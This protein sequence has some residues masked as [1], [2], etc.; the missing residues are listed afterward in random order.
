MRGIPEILEHSRTIDGGPVHRHQRAQ[1]KG[2]KL[3]KV[4]LQW[5]T[6]QEHRYNVLVRLDRQLPFFLDLRRL[7]RVIAPENNDDGGLADRVLD[8]WSPALA[9]ADA[10]DSL[11]DTEAN[12]TQEMHDRS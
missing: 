10:V 1:I 5:S 6:V 11:E 7:A 2:L 9:I 12:G 8:D 4:R 3:G